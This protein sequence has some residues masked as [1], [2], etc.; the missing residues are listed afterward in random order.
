MASHIDTLRAS[1]LVKA[2]VRLSSCG[3]GLD[4]D[5]EQIP[6]P[7]DRIE[8]RFGDCSCLGREDAAIYFAFCGETL[9]GQVFVQ[10]D[11]NAMAHVWNLRVE[12]G[13]QHR[14]IATALMNTARAW[15]RAHNLKWLRAETQD[16]HVTACMFYRDY[17]FCIGGADHM[18]LHAMP[19]CENETTIYWYLA[20]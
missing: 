17:G 7:F 10:M 11:R 18:Y 14:G 9:V 12:H 16:V 13:H 15:A 4:F 1:I 2:R 19:G 8:P 3:D 5:V 20:I 6:R